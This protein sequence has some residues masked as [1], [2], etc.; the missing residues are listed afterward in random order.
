MAQGNINSDQ[1]ESKNLSFKDLSLQ[2][3][4]SQYYV[5]FR[6][7]LEVTP[8]REKHRGERPNITL[9]GDSMTRFALDVNNGCWVPMLAHKLADFFD[10]NNRGFPGFNTRDAVK[11]LSKEFPQ[12]YI[13]RMELMVLFFGHNDSWQNTLLSVPIEE[14]RENLKKIANYF[15]DRDFPF[16][17]MIFISPTSYHD[18]ASAIY[19]SKKGWKNL[20]KSEEHMKQY[21]D[22]TVNVAQE[23]GITCLDF[24]SIAKNCDQFSEL[25]YDGLHLSRTGADL[26]YLHLW[27]LVK[28]NLEKNFGKPIYNMFTQPPSDSR[29]DLLKELRFI[30]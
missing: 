19:N 22:C 7:G 4:Q 23:F 16:S 24:Y 5:D 10:T 13:D 15:N 6:V 8:F 27:P 17:K 20:T 21:A 11:M 1:H 30:K 9:F 29:V 14:Y 3:Q 26:L 25:F 12:S 18:E 2:E 28:E